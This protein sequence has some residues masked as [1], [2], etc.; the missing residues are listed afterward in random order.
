MILCHKCSGTFNNVPELNGCQCMF[1]YP[2]G[3]EKDITLEAAK[4]VQFQQELDWL[5]L[6]VG[7]KRPANDPNWLRTIE[8]LLKVRV[9]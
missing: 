4:A 2:R 7:Q 6:Y 1:G 9:K 5:E 8:R 3:F